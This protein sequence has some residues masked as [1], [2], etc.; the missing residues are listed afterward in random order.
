MNIKDFLI[1]NGYKISEE[2]SAMKMK[3]DCKW[4]AFYK[5]KTDNLCLCNDREP[6][7]VIYHIE[8]SIGW[9]HFSYYNIEVVNENKLGWVKLEYYGID[10][11]Q[12]MHNLKKYEDA[13]TLA[14]DSNF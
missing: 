12:L 10:E 4:V 7:V 1:S 6:Q 13:L 3:E 14:W 2:S 9:H 11:E 5:L 8:G